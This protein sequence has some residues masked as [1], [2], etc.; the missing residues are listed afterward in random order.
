[1]FNCIQRAHQNTL[2]SLP[3]VFVSV[4][5]C[6]IVY[7]KFAA[8]CGALYVTSRFSFAWGYYTGDPKNRARG[9]YGAIGMLGLF[10]A[11]FVSAIRQIGCFDS[12]LPF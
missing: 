5:L 12:Y 2:E 11:M 3:V 6:G 7:P 10:F 8:A 9:K 4:L 1:M